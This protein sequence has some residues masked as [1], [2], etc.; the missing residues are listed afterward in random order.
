VVLGYSNLVG[1]LRSYQVILRTYI[2]AGLTIFDNRFSLTVRS[3]KQSYY[4]LAVPNICGIARYLWYRARYLRKMMVIVTDI[5]QKLNSIE[6]KETL[7]V[8]DY[9]QLFSHIFGR[10]I[11]RSVNK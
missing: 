1:V 7:I 6:R 3:Y 11:L 10:T 9:W 2:S 8:T 5:W 4:K